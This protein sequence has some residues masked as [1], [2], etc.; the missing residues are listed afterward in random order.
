MIVIDADAHVMESEQTWAYLEPE[1]HARRPVVVTLPEDTSLGVFNAA[2]LI[3]EKIN[4]FGASP[5]VGTRSLKKRYSLDSQNL[6]NA[7]ARLQDMNQRQTDYQVIHPTFGLLNLCED[8][9]LEAA[10]MRSYNT[11]LAK[12]YQESGGRLL[13]AAMVPFRS[14][15]LAVKEIQRVAE[16]GGAVAVY[17]RGLEWDRPLHDRSF[18][19]IYE[20]AQRHN[21][22]IS[23]HV[24]SGSPGMRNLFSTQARLR[25]EEP[26]WP[27]GMKRLIGPVTVQFGFYSLAESTLAVDFPNL[28]WGFL[29]ATGSEWLLGAVGALERAHKGHSRRLFD[30]GRIF[31][32][33]E[34]NEDLGYMA[35]RFGSDFMVFGS[36]MPHQDEAAHSNLVDEFGPPA[37]KLGQE[38]K[39][40][41]FWRNAA[42]LYNFVPQKF[43]PAA[44]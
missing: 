19:P 44:R 17:V 41:L 30:E 22:A 12:Q 7:E 32:S 18:Y 15:E 39:E 38:F 23:V 34:P 28:R 16:L 8:V 3:D 21:L 14:P 31:V 40:K 4:V 25:G 29:E 11:F 1:Y 9:E 35:N 42:R 24:G 20:E 26:F 37:D 33:V 36:D 13:Y 10:L 2:W 6:W 43:A 5:A 27:G